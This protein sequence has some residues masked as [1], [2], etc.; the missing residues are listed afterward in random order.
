M[1]PFHSGRRRTDVHPDVV[2]PVGAVYLAPSTNWS[3]SHILS[4]KIRVQTLLGRFDGRL[5]V[6]NIISG[7]SSIG[8][9]LNET[10]P[11]RDF[12]SIFKNCYPK[13]EVIGSSPIHR[14]VGH[15]QQFR[16]MAL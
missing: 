10:N 15:I 11:A 8:R 5:V 1:S 3:G 2:R 16:P 12:N 6:S 7:G 4:V 14:A 13:A 9:A